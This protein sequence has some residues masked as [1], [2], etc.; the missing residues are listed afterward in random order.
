[1]RRGILFLGV[2]T[3]GACGP[4]ADPLLEFESVLTLDASVAKDATLR[5]SDA[6]L[7]FP[8]CDAGLTEVPL[9]TLP[10]SCSPCPTAVPNN[11]DPCDTSIQC[12]FGSDPRLGC[13][14]IAACWGH[15]TD[16]GWV[17]GWVGQWSVDVPAPCG[18]LFSGPG[19]G[20]VP[21]T[22][23]PTTMWCLD[24][25]TVRDTPLGCPCVDQGSLFEGMECYNG[26]FVVPPAPPPP[27][28]NP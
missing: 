24:T 25:S 4:G 12:E 6:G 21:C 7:G 20:F 27:P 17:A 5:V 9:P 15:A 23:T 16:A 14:T 8:T 10:P 28:P 26:R 18:P 11:T 2:A 13:N 19:C 22:D 3:L 1:M